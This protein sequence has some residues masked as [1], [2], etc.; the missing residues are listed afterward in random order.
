MERSINHLFPSRHCQVNRPQQKQPT[1]S[2]HV[3]IY[4]F[5]FIHKLH[6]HVTKIRL[7]HGTVSLYQVIKINGLT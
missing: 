3:P 6:T 5:Y 4:Q 7:K 1:L 2:V